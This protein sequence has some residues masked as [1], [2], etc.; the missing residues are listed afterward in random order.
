MARQ[1]TNKLLHKAKKSK[2]DEFYTQYVDIQKEVEAYLEYNPDT[3]RDKVVYCNCDDPFESN[4][5]R[6]FVLNFERIGLK[7][8]ITTSYK[9]SPFAN[10]QLELFGDNNTITQTKGRPKITANKFIINSVGDIDGDGEFNLK[11]VALQLKQNK[12][13]EW[14]PLEGDGDFRSAESISLL[15]Q[16]DIVITNPRW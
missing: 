11:D 1:A 13:N 4:L 7:Q 2:S 9:P 3:L 10:T 16:S 8:L 12:Q 14:T 5:F 15:K 6:Y